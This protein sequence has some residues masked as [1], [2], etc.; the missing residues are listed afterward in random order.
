[1]K[2]YWIYRF[3]EPFAHCLPLWICRRVE[4]CVAFFWRIFDRSGVAATRANQRIRLGPDASKREVNAAVRRVYLTFS[5]IITEFMGGARFAG[6]WIDR[7]VTMEGIE[8]IERALAGGR[9]VVACGAHLG[10]FENG[11]AS[12]QRRGYSTAALIKMFDDERSNVLFARQR[13]TR[14]YRVLPVGSGTRAALECLRK[15]RVLGVLGDRNYGEPG[16]VVTLFGRPVRLP[17][18]PARLALA[19]RCPLVPSFTRYEGK[20]H[21]I[22][23]EPPIERPEGLP[24]REAARRMTAAFAERL[25]KVLASH[26]DQWCIF[27]PF[28][29]IQGPEGPGAESVT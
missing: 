14:G 21:R 25:E 18:G 27:Y 5:R 11:P 4:H 17:T 28:W 23:F 29:E 22:V 6:E 26:G 1:M 7:N 12:A 15:N 10:N 16:E 2:M 19:A 3:A 8:H 20:Q 13:V 9:G 24:R